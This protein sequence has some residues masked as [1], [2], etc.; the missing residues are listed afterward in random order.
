MT[1]EGR[2]S[3]AILGCG[4]IAGAFADRSARPTTHAQALDAAPPF[5]LVAVSDAEPARAQAFASRWNVR[6]VCTKAELGAAGLDLVVVATPDRK[7]AAHL[8][9]LLAGRR[10][11]RIIVMEKP[12]CASPQELAQ[13]GP[14]LGAKSDTTVVVNHGRR[15]DRGHQAVRDLVSAREL[16]VVVGVRWV[17]YGGWLHNGVH[18][19]DTLRMLLGGEIEPVAPRPGCDGRAGDPC[20]DGD[21]RCGAWP[22]ARILVE[23]HPE[24][25]FQL[26]EGEI[27]LQEGR[28]RLLDFGN[29]ILVDR[30]RVNALGEREL[31]D[32]REIDRTGTPTAMQTLYE[33]CARYLEDGDDT[34]VSRCGAA[35]ASATMRTMFDAMPRRWA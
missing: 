29:Q 35:Q 27:R 16:G 32:T 31:K 7:H 22:D 26:F 5:A 19:I 34:I 11:P 30:V 12:L 3:A 4:R 20:L 17:Y 33:L 6:N 24:S 13:L 14:L 10:P 18:V 28:V 1:A 21:F 25:A 9:G 15:L 2:L 23:S 8:A